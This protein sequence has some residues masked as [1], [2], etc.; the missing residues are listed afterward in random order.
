MTMVEDG[1]D[2][3]GDSFGAMPDVKPDVIVAEVKPET[4]PARPLGA[5]CAEDSQCGSGICVSG[6]SGGGG[7][8]CCNG[9]PSACSTCT[10]GYVTPKPDGSTGCGV[11]RA[12]KLVDVVADGESCGETCGGP[13]GPG[14][15]GALTAQTVAIRSVCRAGL[16]VTTETDCSKKVCPATCNQM[17]YIGCFLNSDGSGGGTGGGN[18]PVAGA[19]CRCVGGS[20]FC[21]AAL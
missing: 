4:M 20:S 11:C 1:S 19:A 15:D 8:V 14:Y 13:L 21:S 5:G 17:R 12:G 10:G 16:C 6:S 7:G 3:A 18:L 9:R 2:A